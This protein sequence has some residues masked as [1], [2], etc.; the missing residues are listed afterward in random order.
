MAGV[1]GPRHIVRGELQPVAGVSRF[2][3]SGG[4]GRSRARLHHNRGRGCA[5]GGERYRRALGS[6]Y[7]QCLC[8]RKATSLSRLHHRWFVLPGWIAFLVRGD[9]RLPAVLAIGFASSLRVHRFRNGGD[10]GWRDA[11]SAAESSGSAVDGNGCCG[12]LLHTDPGSLHRNA[13]HPGDVAAA[14]G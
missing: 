9:A 8:D 13:A 7:Q 10:P 12:H 3:F 6:G 14:A 2:I 4:I 1:D 11:K 5:R